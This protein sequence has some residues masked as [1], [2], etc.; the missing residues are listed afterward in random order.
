MP[1]IDTRID[2]VS[3]AFARN[4]DHTLGIL[5]EVRALEQRTRDRSAQSRP[6]FEKR[7]QLLPRERI[8]LLLDPG[9]SYLE[10]STLAGYGWTTRTWPNA[11]PAPV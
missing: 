10:L 5:A 11:F 9:S 1:L 2:P 6:L 7:G 8:A 3:E 4:R